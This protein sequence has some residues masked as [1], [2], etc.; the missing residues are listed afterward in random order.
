MHSTPASKPLLSIEQ[1]S[2]SFTQGQQLSPAVKQVSLQLQPGE[3]LALVGES[4]SGKSVT[5]N[6][7][8]RLLPAS[9]QMMGKILY[10]GEDLLSLPETAMQQIR[11]QQIAMIFQE[12]MS[13]LNPL[14]R[15]GKQISEM[16]LQ[17]QRLTKAEASAK[18]LELLRL[19]EIPQP[20]QRIKAYPHELSG[21]Q[22]Q[23]VMI[24]MALAN[25]PKL[26]IADE[27]TTALDV[28]VQKTILE[29]LQRLQ[30]KMGMAILLIT[31]DL[32]LVRRVADRVCVMQQG[33]LVEQ[34]ATEQLFENPQHPYTQSLLAAEPSGL[35][36]A[37]EVGEPL[38]T[39][40]KLKVWYPIKSGFLQRTREHIKAVDEISLQLKRGQ[41]LG[42]VG[43][44]GSGKSTLGL[45]ILRLIHSQGGI[46]FDQQPINQFNQQQVRPLRRR[47][48]VV[49]Q[50]PFGSLS[51]RMSISQ[52]IGEGLEIHQIG[53]PEQRQQMIIQALQEV[54]LDPDSRHRY[55]HEFS[56]GQRQRVAIAR[57]LV[58]K[59]D[60]I[61]L[62]EP[63]SALDR[64]VQRQ[65]IELLRDLQ[66]KYNL[67]YI[68]ISHDLAVV[69]ALCHQLIVMRQGK[70]VEQGSAASLFSAPQHPY[71][72]QL[73]EAAFMA[74]AASN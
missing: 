28:T 38:L 20:E 58:L 24:A 4:G 43:E 13:S 66:V 61:V 32:N 27:P 3:T 26:L 44:S 19:V 10:Q 72:Q 45:A 59:P 74:P 53:D 69:K 15:I 68:F 39:V 30:Q 70:V 25:E 60:L 52:I 35:P 7:I 5:A 8:L 21:G 17:H 47:L 29:L 57:A 23:R 33:C 49:F 11:G 67:T 41:S 2:V 12:P 16:I 46:N 50:D 37:T 54:G 36:A 63:T 31:H 40:D 14:Q 64:S 71:T 65:V 9:A 1:L 22:R 51:P 73:L 55:P 34:A 62:D 42:V 56:G 18:A 6:A 48:Q